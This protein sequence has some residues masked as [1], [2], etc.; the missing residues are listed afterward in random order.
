MI[1]HPCPGRL[2]VMASDSR[3][4][5]VSTMSGSIIRNS[6]FWVLAVLGLALGAAGAAAQERPDQFYTDMRTAV[7]S[8]EPGAVGRPRDKSEGPVFLILMELAVAGGSVMIYAFNDGTTSLYNSKGGALLGFGTKESVRMASR[9][10]LAAAQLLHGKAETVTEFPGPP[11]HHVAFYFK[12]FDG[13]RGYMAPGD[14]LANNKDEMSALFHAG[15]AVM[16]E[17][18]AI[19]EQLKNKKQE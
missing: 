4:Y 6:I 1:A 7:L 3:C 16:L 18:F 13:A 10:F 12:T 5:G 15:Y 9:K 17:L 19:E 14:D 11:P 2:A 8:L